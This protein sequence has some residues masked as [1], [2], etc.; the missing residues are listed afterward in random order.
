V[1]LVVD[2][3]EGA[4]DLV[5]KPVGALLAGHP[6]V[7]GTSLSIDGEVISVLNSSGLERWLSIRM[8]KGPASAMMC[9]A[10]GVNPASPGERT[11]VLVVDDSISVRRAVARQLSSLGLD[12]HEVSDGQEALGN[13]RDSRYGLVLTDL[14]MPKLD[15]FALL[16]EMKRSANLATVPVIV[17]SSRDDSKTRERVLDLGARALLSKPVDPQELI[18]VIGPLLP[19]VGA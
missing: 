18:R 12:V 13:L 10:P 15:G 8:A 6:L 7:S 16:A 19:G 1:V 4:V 14:D 3:I 17:A 5:I 11:A 2:S 9:P